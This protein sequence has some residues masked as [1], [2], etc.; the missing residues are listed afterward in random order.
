MKRKC[1]LFLA[2]HISIKHELHKS[3][4]GSVRLLLKKQRIEHPKCRTIRPKQKQKT[5]PQHE[6]SVKICQRWKIAFYLVEMCSTRDKVK[7]SF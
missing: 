6:N 7:A 2:S 1:D 4:I 5:S 3:S